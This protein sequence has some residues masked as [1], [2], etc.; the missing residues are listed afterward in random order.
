MF[1]ILYEDYENFEKREIEWFQFNDK[2]FGIKEKDFKKFE[3]E[4]FEFD[5][6]KY[7]YYL[8]AKEI[9]FI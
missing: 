3:E 6:D 4:Y 2:V 1:L 5:K 8:M 7:Y 9:K